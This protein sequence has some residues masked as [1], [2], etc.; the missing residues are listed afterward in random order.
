M[1]DR[2]SPSALSSYPSNGSNLVFSE[3]FS[4]ILATAIIIVS[5]FLVNEFFSIGVYMYPSYDPSLRF[6]LSD[7][8]SPS[9]STL[10]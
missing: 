5:V 4:L 8:F 3:L 7:G 10:F 6:T 1:G 9:R 2:F